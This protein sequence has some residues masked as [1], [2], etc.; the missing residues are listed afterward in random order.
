MQAALLHVRHRPLPRLLPGELIFALVAE[1]YLIHPS[2]GLLQEKS[3]VYQ[4]LG[5]PHGLRVDQRG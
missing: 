5:T 3:V 4:R 1:G 2:L